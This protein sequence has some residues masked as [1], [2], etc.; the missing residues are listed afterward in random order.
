M[1]LDGRWRR[2]IELDESGTVI[3]LDQ[4]RLPHA[5]AWMTLPDLA[6]AARAIR[7]MHVRGAPLIGATAAY[8][9]ALALR[10]DPR[11]LDAACAELAATRPT[12]VNLRWALTAM[13]TRLADVAPS[14]RADVAWAEAGRICDDDAARNEAIGRHG[15]ALIR[16][17][18]ERAGD[19][20]V[21]VLTHCNAGWVAT[22][23]WG[24]A[25]APIYMAH[26]AG[27]PIAVWVDETRPRNQGLLT[28]WELA[29]HGVAHTLIADNAGG[30]LMQRGQVDLCIV[31]TDRTTRTGDV[32]NKIGTYLKALAAHDNRVPF[33]V[34]APSPSIDWTVDDGAA[35]PI[36][37]RSGD[38][39]RW[40]AGFD[41]A[42]APARVALVGASTAVANPA[43]DVTPARLVTSI[44]TE[45]G[46]APATTAGLAA[47]FPEHAR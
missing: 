37:E 5:V 36:E 8:G 9:V 12:A 17:A 42:G 28:A 30:H 44:I 41:A 27:L 26:E 31:G 39:V 45:R 29:Q 10:A 20:P 11:S 14:E 4:A 16:A 24:T 18:A 7:D 3:V 33:H 21:R 13:Q 1:K 22:V 34:A 47:L 46:V 19:R 15:L 32:C 2:A 25:L 35:I 43:F 40:V 23:D 38:E 6:T